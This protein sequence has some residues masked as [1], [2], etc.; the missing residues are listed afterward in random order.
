ML[1]SEIQFNSHFGWDVMP[2]TEIENFI[3]SKE[4]VMEGDSGTFCIFNGGDL[5]HRG[6][7]VNTGRRVALQVIFG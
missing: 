7:L 5:L 2:E 1:P 4:V 6:G 3:S